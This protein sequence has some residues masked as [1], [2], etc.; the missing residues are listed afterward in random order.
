MRIL[1]TGQESSMRRT[2]FNLKEPTMVA[3]ETMRA[4]KLR[5]F[6]MLLGVILSVTT[7]IVVISRIEGMNQYIADH[8][9]NM[10]VNV[11]LVNRFPIITS[12]E[13]YVK[14]E[15]RNRKITWDDYE[16]LRDN[17]KQAKAVGVQVNTLGKVRYNT[18]SL[19]DAE[20]RRV[21]ANISQMAV[22][23]PATGRYIS[24][25]AYDNRTPVTIIGP[26]GATTRLP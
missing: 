7:L 17:M 3:L 6:L 14:A 2:G 26:E 22:E 8:V 4:H 10:G 12:L 9:A 11:F 18:E 25:R 16:F 5:S 20:I 1:A 21:T 15:R 24:D 23:E 13:E 19:E